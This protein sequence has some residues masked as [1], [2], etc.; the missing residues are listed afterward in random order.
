[1]KLI[2]LVTLVTKD[3]E[4][5]PGDELEVKDPKE[6]KGLIDRGFAKAVAAKAAAKAW[7]DAEAEAAAAKA[8][9]DAE[10]E[11]AAAK[12]KADAEAAVKQ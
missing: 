6:A 12:A 9:A 3:G 10:A 5:P 7:V 1:M 11:A 2:A 8:K 4:I